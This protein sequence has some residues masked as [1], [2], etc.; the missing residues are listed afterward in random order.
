MTPLR[1]LLAIATIAIACAGPPGAPEPDRSG[2]WGYVQLVPREGVHPSSSGSYGDRRVQGAE[3]VD[4]SRPGFVV[5][6][7]ADAVSSAPST[8]TL[9]IVD[10][11]VGPKIEPETL[12]VRAGDVVDIENT[13]G[14]THLLSVPRDGVIRRVAPRDHLRVEVDDPGRHDF[15]LVDGGA[16]ASVVFAAPG[17]MTVVDGAGRFELVDVSPGHHV[18][19]AWHPRFPPAEQPVDL[20]RGANARVDVSIGVGRD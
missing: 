14:A 7:L 11:R 18:L 1:I 2:V 5:V 10:G 4:Y 17:P 9:R 13:S 8:A 20:P 16:A 6:Y 19:H 3:L 15:F 12:A